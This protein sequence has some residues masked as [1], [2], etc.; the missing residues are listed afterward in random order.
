MTMSDIQKSLK[1]QLYLVFFLLIILFIFNNFAADFSLYWI[2]RWLD[3]PMHFI[4]GALISWLAYIAFALWRS[5]YNIP[6]IYAIIFSFGL[7]FIWEVMEFYFKVAQLIPDYMLDST[8][9]ILMDMIGGLVVYAVW[10]RASG[11]F[12][13]NE[14]N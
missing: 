12:N 5:D 14:N 11:K 10:D 9:D 7:G 1:K 6:W 8:K 4:G 2:Y 13:T 3:L